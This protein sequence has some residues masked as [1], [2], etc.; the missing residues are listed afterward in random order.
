MAAPEGNEYYLLRT[1]DGRDKQYKKPENLV[2]ACN[3]YFTFC[4]GNPLIEVEQSRSRKSKKELEITE[5]S[6]KVEDTG[7]IELPKMR[8]FTLE[9]LCNFIDLSVEGFKLYEK[10]KDFVGVTTRVR[11]II[12]NQKFEGAAAGFLNANIIARD[13]GL[14]NVNSNE[15]TGKDGTPL[16]MGEVTVYLPDNNRDKKA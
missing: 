3:E 10:R 6:I 5:D 12:Y 14:R 13:L 2:E 9:G 8:P 16:Q 7:L 11:Q 1:K 15:H 4:L